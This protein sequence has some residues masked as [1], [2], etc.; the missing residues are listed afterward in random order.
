MQEYS[1]RKKLRSLVCFKWSKD[2]KL[3]RTGVER[4]N[5]EEG[6][7][8]RKAFSPSAPLITFLELRGACNNGNCSEMSAQIMA[9]GSKELEMSISC[10][11]SSISLYFFLLSLSGPPDELQRPE[12]LL[13][14]A[15]L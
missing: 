2:R 4:E 6:S 7:H 3:Q 12:W 14:S 9:P 15:F 8:K 10:H 11:F 5:T 1:I 13:L